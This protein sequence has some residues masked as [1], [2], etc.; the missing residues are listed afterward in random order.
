MII[1]REGVRL[2]ARDLTP[3]A[4]NEAV[5]LFQ[6]SMS[7]RA[8]AAKLGISKSEAGRLRQRAE[9]EALLGQGDDTHG[10][11]GSVSN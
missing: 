6:Q 7:V 9:A 8:V 4:F 11:N 10:L 1:G 2:L 5:N 3:P